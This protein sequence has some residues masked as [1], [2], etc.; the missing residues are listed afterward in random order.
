MG[1]VRTKPTWSWFWWETWR[2]QKKAME[3]V[4]LLLNK[5]AAL[6]WKTQKT[7]GGQVFLTLVFTGENSLQE[8]QAPEISGKIYHKEDL[9]LEDENQIR[10]LLNKL[11][12]HNST[13]PNGI[14][15]WMLRG[16][17][18]VTA[19]IL[20]LYRSWWLGKV[21]HDWKKSHFNSIISPCDIFLQGTL[22]WPGSEKSSFIDFIL[23]EKKI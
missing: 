19:R 13:A 10:E 16:L 23:K 20:T 9:P 22:L 18:R 8:S 17:C 7:R 12:K 6:C 21:S 1:F 4:D 5:T 11:D 15:P 3:N 14:H 2:Q